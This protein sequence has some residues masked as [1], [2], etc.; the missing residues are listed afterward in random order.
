M[1]KEWNVGTLLGVSCGYWQGCTVQA[2]VRLKIF[3]V[4]GETK[5]AAREVAKSTGSDIRATGLLLDALAAMG[6]LIKIDT[7]YANSEFS[8]KFLVADA[9]AYMG[10][11]ILHH[12]QIFDGWGQLDEAVMTGRRVERR[13]YG[14]EI[15]RENFLMGMFNLAMMVAPQ[16]A[17]KFKLS[18]RKRLL[19][20]GGGPGTYA[21]HFCKANPE[22]KA[23]IL[24]R[25]TTEPFAR[26]TVAKFKLAERIDFIGGDF[27]IDPILGGPYDCAWLSH[28]LHSNTSE[29]CQ[30]CLKKTVETLEPGGVI[31]IHDFILDDTKDGPEFPALFALNMLVGTEHGRSYSRGE[32]TAMLERTGVVDITHHKLDIPNDSSVITGVKKK[33]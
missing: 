4:L 7:E 10:H 20:L 33:D 23:V 27:N 12:H 8:R 15:E 13:S 30:A 19:D 14:E 2:G 25:P 21:I 1:A 24:D 9:P 26:E 18:G 32:I 17:A 16:M 28:I 6:L 29:Q 11:I 3:T 22:L 31:L 5:Y